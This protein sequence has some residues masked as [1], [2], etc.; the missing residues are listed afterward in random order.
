MTM[1]QSAALGSISHGTL[2]ECD[3][4]EAFMHELEWQIRRNGEH[5]SRPENFS[6]RDRL[7]ALV[8]DAGDCFD[9]YGE[10]IAEDKQELASKLVNQELPD[11][12]GEFAAPYCYFGAH[13]G[14]GSDFGFWPADIEEIKEQVEFVSSKGAEYPADDY[15]GEWLHINERGNCTLYVREDSGKDRKIW[16]CV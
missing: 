11:A 13:M 10:D 6:E 14:D 8:G 3:L 7:N 12:L 15:R 1:K 2:R 5:Y 16:G 9:E 4:L